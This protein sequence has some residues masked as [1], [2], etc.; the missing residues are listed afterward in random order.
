MHQGTVVD[1]GNAMVRGMW[2]VRRKPPSCAKTTFCYEKLFMMQMEVFRKISERG[3]KG[4]REKAQSH[5]SF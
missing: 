4:R 2:G 3:G 1:L 5:F